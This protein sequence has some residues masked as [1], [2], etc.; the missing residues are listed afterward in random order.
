[1]QKP[2]LDAGMRFQ[3]NSECVTQAQ[4]QTGQLNRIRAGKHRRCLGRNDVVEVFHRNAKIHD[5][6]QPTLPVQQLDHFSR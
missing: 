1:M 4:G 2:T 3:R 5:R 6:Q